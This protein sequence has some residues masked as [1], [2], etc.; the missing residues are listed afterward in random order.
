[1]RRAWQNY[2]TRQLDR[3]DRIAQRAVAQ[4]V[5]EEERARQAEIAELRD[6]V[7][8]L[9]NELRAIGQD[10]SRGLRAVPASGPTALI[11]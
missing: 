11:A 9:E 8:T 5:I 2:I 1:L 10:R 4:V 3:R 6:R 7:L